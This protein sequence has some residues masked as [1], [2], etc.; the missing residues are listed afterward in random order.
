MMLI[1]VE[2]YMFVN[3]KRNKQNEIN[4]SIHVPGTG[5]TGLLAIGTTT[6]A[7]QSSRTHQ[8][9]AGMLFN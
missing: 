7:M 2:A 5:A 3:K 6:H 8:L 9:L 4:S 1:N